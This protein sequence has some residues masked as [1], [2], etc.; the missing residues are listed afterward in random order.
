M[1]NPRSAHTFRTCCPRCRPEGRDSQGVFA[2]LPSRRLSK[3]CGWSSGRNRLWRLG[4]FD[5]S[6]SDA[7]VRESTVSLL[8]DSPPF[9]GVYWV[10]RV[11]T[12]G[13]EP[14]TS[15]LRVVRSTSELCRRTP[16]YSHHANISTADQGHGVARGRSFRSEGRSEQIHYSV[17]CFRQ[18]ET[19]LH[20]REWDTDTSVCCRYLTPSINASVYSNIYTGLGQWFRAPSSKSCSNAW[21]PFNVGSYPETSGRSSE[22]ICCQIF[23][24]SSAK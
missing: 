5:A 22:M 10:L 2:D 18:A 24:I 7:R 23:S 8:L 11:A 13:I 1:G 9:E 15:P 4:P 16:C 19:I 6:R 12:K 17:N 20:E 21:M 3:P 14:L